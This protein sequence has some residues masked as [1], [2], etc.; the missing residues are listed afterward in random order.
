MGGVVSSTV[1]A[2]MEIA[3]IYALIGS[4]D[5]TF[6]LEKKM[7]VMMILMVVFLVVGGPGGHM[8]SHGANSSPSQASQSHEHGSAKPDAEK[9]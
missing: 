2:V 1:P 3:A 6:Y 4:H 7:A 8:G 5:I 9:P